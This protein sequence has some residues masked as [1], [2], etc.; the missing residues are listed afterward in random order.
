[1]A[2]GKID[3]LCEYIENNKAENYP[4][5]NDSLRDSTD[6]IKN[7]YLKMLAVIL[8]QAGEITDGQLTIY[9][10]IWAGAQSELAAEEF[11]RMALSVEIE[12]FVNF[13]GECKEIDL[14][15][16]FVLDAIILIGVEEKK[17]EQIRLVVGFCEAL[18]IAKEEIRYL[19]AM[20]KAIL[21]LSD[22][23][24]IDAYEVKIDSI[25]DMIFQG[26]MHLITKSCICGNDNLTI[27]Q[28]SCAEDV[29]LQMLEKL[30]EVDTPNIKLVNL[31]IDLD[32]YCMCFVEKASVILESCV[33][34]RGRKHPITFDN[35]E[36]VEIINTEFMDFDSRTLCVEK[37]GSVWI[38]GCKFINCKYK[39]EDYG[40]NWD[41]LG[42]VIYSESLKNGIIN[43]E[44]SSF[45]NC[46]GMNGNY[47]SKSAFISNVQCEVCG[48]KF[49][50]CWH[51][52]G[53]RYCGGGRDEDKPERTMF[54]HNSKAINCVYKNSAKFC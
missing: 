9:K 41:K 36:K 27:F 25:P 14:K 24:Y 35:C 29:N 43:I 8:Q 49:I 45:K 22:S 15:Y 1:M 26:Y 5:K 42:G 4:I 17:E 32:E 54:T 52:N 16:N 28:P 40:E 23:A 47:Y 6:F 44:N 31:E 34:R 13:T 37:V 53:M 18:G 10:R 46:G 11:L 38:E 48:C 19:A 21:E 3:L 20:A 2:K 39:Y 33:I 51:W 7:G 50:D 30:R 12:D